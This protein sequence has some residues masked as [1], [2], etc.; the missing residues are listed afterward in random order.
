MI[1]DF[2]E[3]IVHKWVLEQL[4]TVLEAHM[5]RNIRTPVGVRN[6]TIVYSAPLNRSHAYTQRPKW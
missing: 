1:G 5:D 4:I 6:K 3:D 2:G